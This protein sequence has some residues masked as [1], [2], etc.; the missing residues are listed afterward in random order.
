M[1]VRGW[2]LGLLAVSAPAA[3]EWQKATTPHFVIYSDT[4]T[5]AITTLATRLE[6]VDAAMRL[7]YSMPD[8]PESAANPVT[9]YV[10]DDAA[11]IRKLSRRSDIAGFYVGRADGSVA[12]TPRRGEGAGPG[13]LSPQIVLFHEYAHHLLLSNSTTAFPAWFSEGYAEFVATAR[14]DEGV[15]VLGGGAQHRAYGLFAPKSLPM[16][17]LF[18]PSAKLDAQQRDQIYGY[19]WLLTHYLMFDPKRR[20]SFQAYLKAINSGTPSLKAATDAF[21]DLKELDRA[22]RKYLFA[23]TLPAFSIKNERL[24]TP[25]IDLRYLTPG[26]RALIDMRMVSTRGVDEKEAAT[27]YARASAAAKSHPADAVAQGWLAEMAYDAGR[28]DEAEAA[29]DRALAADP[30]AVQALLYK[31]RVRLRRAVAAK[32][33]DPKLWGEARSWVVKAN[34][35]NPNAAG[36]LALYYDSFAMAGAKPNKSA[37]AGIHRAVE[38]VPQ[39]G[40]LRFRSAS[41]LLIDGETERAKQ[42][43]RPLAFDPHGGV[44]NPAARLIAMIDKG[45]AGPAALAALAVEEDAKATV[46]D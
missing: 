3:A 7:V 24:P 37:V 31:G 4:S 10:L 12:F 18:E 41:Q 11:A 21:G 46:P 34:R 30:K 27:L 1:G 2:A 8:T 36:A 19:G 33:T 40:G 23:R 45:T 9:V 22:L 16:A 17:T 43:L 38:L 20:A 42:A 32:A 6:R 35:V 13:S 15:T 44:N 25:R 39:D 14:F 28:D 29:A 26:E 5:E